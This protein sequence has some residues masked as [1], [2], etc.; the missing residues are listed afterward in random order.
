MGGHCQAGSSLDLILMVRNSDAHGCMFATEKWRMRI[1]LIEFVFSTITIRAL[2]VD[3]DRWL[4]IYLDHTTSK[5]IFW[6]RY[7]SAIRC[8]HFEA[9]ISESCSLWRDDPLIFSCFFKSMQVNIQCAPR[10]NQWSYQWRFCWRPM[11]KHTLGHSP[12]H[13]HG[14]FDSVIVSGS[15]TLKPRLGAIWFQIAHLRA[16]VWIG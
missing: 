12:A 6:S 3:S 4:C 10:T 14:Q 13:W 9:T 15:G 11:V 5:W 1:E 16:R 8:S 2:E 7:F